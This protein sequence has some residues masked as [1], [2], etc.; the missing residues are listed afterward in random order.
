MNIKPIRYFIN[1]FVKLNPYVTLTQIKVFC[2]TTPKDP[3][4]SELRAAI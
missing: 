1:K 2:I 4:I 3:H